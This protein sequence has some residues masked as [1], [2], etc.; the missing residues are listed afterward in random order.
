MGWCDREEVQDYLGRSIVNIAHDLDLIAGIGY[1][2]GWLRDTSKP[3]LWPF[4][5]DEE[6]L[7]YQKACMFGSFCRLRQDSKKLLYTWGAIWL[8]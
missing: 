1:V 7:H 6:R 8:G 4:W 2:D 3:M 5:S